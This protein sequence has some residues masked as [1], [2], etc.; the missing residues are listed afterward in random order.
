MRKWEGGIWSSLGLCG[1]LRT[2]STYN[3]TFNKTDPYLKKQMNQEA[4]QGLSQ[5][6]IL[7]YCDTMCLEKNGSVLLV[8]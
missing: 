7:L 3:S 6:C 1:L 5:P 8:R 2:N 4:S